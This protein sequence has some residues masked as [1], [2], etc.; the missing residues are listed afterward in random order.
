MLVFLAIFKELDFLFII[1]KDI[2]KFSVYFSHDVSCFCQD[3]LFMI[4]YDT[5]TI[6]HILFK[7]T[8]L[9]VGFRDNQKPPSVLL[10]RP[11]KFPLIPVFS[12]FLPLRK[13]AFLG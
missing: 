6:K 10:P 5:G 4:N 12:E 3:F 2:Y 13:A 7:I 1:V 9:Q 11:V 8:D